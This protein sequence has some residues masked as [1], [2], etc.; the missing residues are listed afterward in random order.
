MKSSNVSKVVQRIILA[1][2]ILG[3]LTITPNFTLDPINISKYLVISILSLPIFVFAIY[4]R[5]E[6]P[7]KVFLLGGLFLIFMILSLIF[8]P[9][10]RWK[11]IYG[12]YGRNTGILTY[13]SLLTL[14]LATIILTD[15]EF[16]SKIVKALIFC[17]TVNLFYAIVQYFGI[18]PVNWSNSYQ[19]NVVG[20]FGNPNFVSSFLAISSIVIMSQLL[21]SKSKRIQFLIVI[22]LLLNLFAI[23]QTKSIQGLALISF[24]VIAIIYLGYLKNKSL[25]F[26]LTYLCFIGIITIVTLLG[27]FNQGPMSSMLSS[28]TVKLRSFYWGAGIK[29]ALENPV[30]GVGID[31]YGDWYRAYRTKEAATF[32]GP[33]IVTN[34]AHNVFIDLLA[35]GGVALFLVYVLLN[36]LILNSSLKLLRKTKFRDAWVI[37]LVLGWVAY[38]IQSIISINQLGLALWGW[39]LGGSILG[40]E[41]NVN[42]QP[43]KAESRRPEHRNLKKL[44]LIVTTLTSLSLSSTPFLKDMKFLSALESGEVEKIN[45]ATYSFPQNSHYFRIAAEVYA[46]NDLR[47]EE[48]QVLVAAVKSNSRDFDAWR[49]ISVNP[50]SSTSDI[51]KAKKSLRLLDPFYD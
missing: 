18:D 27:L 11:Q 32:N 12:D 16:S 23:F 30:F 8:N 40:L 25:V 3:T 37:S 36:V 5:H 35:G 51:N 22:L 41:K 43:N 14:L 48:L 21:N 29:M 49:S 4:N 7:I 13:F 45:K 19:I 9:L 33:D 47:K 34:A 10:T 17:G 39:I 38:S 44:I 31:T 6:I 1:I 2:A 20:T 50:F 46:Y 26:R 42:L 15:K 24:G 28:E